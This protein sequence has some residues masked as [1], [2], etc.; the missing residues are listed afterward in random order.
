MVHPGLGQQS[1]NPGIIGVRDEHL[2]IVSL[3]QGLHQGARPMRIDLVED[4]VEDFDQKRRTYGH[5]LTYVDD[6]L[7][8][9]PAHVRKAIEEEIS[10]LW[11]VRIEGQVKQF[12]KH[13]PEA[14]LT[15]LSTVIRWHS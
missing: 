7:I 6:F 4:V 8:V 2:T 15:F 10:R 11:K 9:G 13:N 12:D 1:R 3:S 14:S 5:L